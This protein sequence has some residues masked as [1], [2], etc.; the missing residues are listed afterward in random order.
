VEE[1]LINAFY[2]IWNTLI[3]NPDQDFDAII[4]RF[5]T[6]LAAQLDRILGQS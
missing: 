3:T 5:L 1:R 2:M 6:P 4:T